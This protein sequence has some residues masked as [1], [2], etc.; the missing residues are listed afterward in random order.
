MIKETLE[1]WLRDRKPRIPDQF[2]PHLLGSGDE[3]NAAAGLVE[4]GTEALGRALER[5]AGNHEAA[6]QLLAADAFLT[7][8]CEAVV[9]TGDVRTGLEEVLGSLGDRFR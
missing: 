5:P 2:L 3:S 7:Y 9:Q 1:V 6:F 8:A 4:L